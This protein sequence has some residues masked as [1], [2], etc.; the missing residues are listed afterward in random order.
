MMHLLQTLHRLSKRPLPLAFYALLSLPQTHLSAGSDPSEMAV[1]VKSVD[2]LNVTDGGTIILDG[3]AGS[4]DLGPVS[5][6]CA[7]LNYTHN[8]DANKKIT[9]EVTSGPSAA[10]NDIILTVAVQA[11][12]G[13]KVIYNDAG[14][15]IA[16][17]VVTAMP[18]GALSNRM[19]TYTAR[20]TASGTVVS[21]DTDFNFVVTFTSV[22]E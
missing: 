6:T 20:C 22:D 8:R 7:Q 18:A 3:S 12:A 13:T 15:S 19:V 1:R 17:D 14:P 16:Q 2:D 5:D 4:N 9:A 10:G 11:G 21:A